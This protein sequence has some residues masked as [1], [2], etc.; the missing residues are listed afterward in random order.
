[1]QLWP[2][3]QPPAISFPTLTP[4]Q[5]LRVLELHEGEGRQRARIFLGLSLLCLYSLCN[6]QREFQRKE[7]QEIRERVEKRRPRN[8]DGA[9]RAPGCKFP[10]VPWGWNSLEKTKVVSTASLKF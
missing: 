3:A 10:G 5:G 8:K 1:M 9:G 2:S 7:E 6:S 4:Q